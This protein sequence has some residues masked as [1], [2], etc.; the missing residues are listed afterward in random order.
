MFYPIFMFRR[1]AFAATITLLTNYPQIQL[2]F[3]SLGS[4]TVFFHKF[5]KIV[6]VL[7]GLLEAV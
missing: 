3:I 5:T 4:A 1:L 6:C 2:S 7:F